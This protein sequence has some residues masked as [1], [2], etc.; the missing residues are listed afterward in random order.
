MELDIDLALAAAHAQRDAVVAH[1]S[2][3]VMY[4]EI[5]GTIVWAS[6]ATQ[7]LFGVAVD[8]IIGRNGLELIHPDDRERALVDL[9][10]ISGFGET[11]RCE[12]RVVSDDGAIYWVEE[13]ATNLIDDPH[14]GYVVANLNNI[15]ARKRDEEAIRLQGRLLDAAGQAIVAIDMAGRVFYWNAAATSIYGWTEAEAHELRAEE[16]LAPAVGWEHEAIAVADRV[17]AGKPWSGDFLTTRKDGSEIPIYLTDTPVFDNDGVQI[18]MIAVSSD[19]TERKQHEQA[20]ARMATHDALTGLANRGL[21]VTALRG[22]TGH[23][24]EL[25]YELRDGEGPE[26]APQD[27]SG[28]S[29]DEL[30][31]RL[32]E[33]FGATEVLDHEE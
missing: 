2:D 16:L 33:D 26:E 6:P 28:L 27:L 25:T 31:E 13:T 8:S 11:V 12:F 10:S 23:S 19:I 18:G 20:Q 29:E 4:F 21:L 22:L 32:R 24:L 14:V 7:S 3:L 15:T 5:D 30:L 1:S 9:M 17:L